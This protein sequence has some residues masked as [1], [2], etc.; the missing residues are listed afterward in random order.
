[1][2]I[3]GV[4]ISPALTHASIKNF[5]IDSNLKP[6]I[7]RYLR[8]FHNITAD[9]IYNDLFGFISNENKFSSASLHF[10]KGLRIQQ[11]YEYKTITPGIRQE[12]E[13]AMAHYTEAIATRPDFADAYH[14]RGV[15][16]SALGKSEDG[17]KDLDQAI[18]IKPDFA[19][20][21]YNRGIMKSRLNRFEEAIKDFRKAI[22]IIPHHIDAWVN[23]IEAYRKS[24]MFDKA[25]TEIKNAQNMNPDDK[26]LIGMVGGMK[27][28]IKA[29]RMKESN[30]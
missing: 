10:E 27:D 14:R 22:G 18:D 29:E 12:L 4:A 15:A 1:M 21:Y 16:K 28:L 9:T 7:L 13:E 8:K 30:E 25:L 26:L 24:K 3:H 17:I 2:S 11:E 23:M 5:P 6:F 19:Q 20:A